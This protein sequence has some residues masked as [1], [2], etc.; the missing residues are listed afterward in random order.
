MPHRLLDMP[1]INHFIEAAILG[2]A[3]GWNAFSFH[4]ASISDED[5][6]KI[7]GPNGVAFVAVMAVVVLWITRIGDAKKEDQRRA[8]EE[9]SRE[10]R[11]AEL[12]ATNRENA[13]SLKALTVESMKIGIKVEHSLA[14]M[15]QQ[16]AGR[17]C[18]AA[19]FKKPEEPA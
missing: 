11:H 18:Q 3:L 1:P 13:E 15:A 16:I 12:V 6:S 7:T 2:L 4:L 17:P 8:K 9:E 14:E 19:I 10:K 5:W